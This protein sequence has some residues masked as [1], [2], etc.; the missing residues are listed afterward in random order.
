[1]SLPIG[2]D[3]AAESSKARSADDATAFI[4]KTY[5]I[6]EDNDDAVRWADDGRSFI[7][8]D[9]DRLQSLIL[10]RYFKHGNYNS[11]VR[12]LHFYGFSKT[13]L[14]NNQA[15][16]R[17]SRFIRNRTDLLAGIVRKSTDTIAQLKKQVVTLNERVQMLTDQNLKLQDMITAL[18]AERGQVPSG[19][20]LAAT[21]SN[22]GGD[23][24]GPETRAQ[25]RTRSRSITDQEAPTSP[26]AK[27]QAGPSSDVGRPWLPDVL[28][29]AG[30]HSSEGRS[31]FARSDV[32]VG[33]DTTAFDRVQRH[34]PSP[35]SARSDP[36]ISPMRPQWA[37]P[38]PRQF[39]P[40]ICE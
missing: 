30:A 2:N 27:K 13:T 1:M 10:P 22:S 37:R 20:M 25:R 3:S 15:E 33:S 40:R 24:K 17:H 21:A 29:G 16:F 7:V 26:R 36:C 23:P 9:C 39:S 38:F 35:S 34:P 6:I 14:P 19:D 32:V 12:Q 11:F 31:C 5:A 28:A 8:T 18:M 4:T